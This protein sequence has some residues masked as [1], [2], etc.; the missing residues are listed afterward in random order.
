MG[1]PPREIGLDL[2]AHHKIFT[3]YIKAVAALLIIST[4]LMVV[5]AALTLLGLNSK[6]FTRKYLFYRIA[7]YFAL[8]AGIGSFGFLFF[9]CRNFRNRHFE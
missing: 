7:M 6:D 4:I 8:F 2:C 3:V 1:S 5:A 9:N